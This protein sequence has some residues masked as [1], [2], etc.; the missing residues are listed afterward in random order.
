LPQASSAFA[1]E[2]SRLPP[3]SRIACVV[4]VGFFCEIVPSRGSKERETGVP[5]LVCPET[6]S[7]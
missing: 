5:P 2:F 4:V 7:Q 6:F 3:S 1:S